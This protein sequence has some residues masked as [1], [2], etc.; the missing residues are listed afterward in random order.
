MNTMLQIFRSILPAR[1]LLTVVLALSLGGCGGWMSQM[2]S[3]KQAVQ[4]KNYP[5]ASV[6]IAK[7]D[8]QKTVTVRLKQTVNDVQ[9]Q[10]IVDTVKTVVPDANNVVVVD[11]GATPN[12]AGGSRPNHK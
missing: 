5:V 7:A 6:G 9:R 8:G 2:S 4:G 3:V 11:G 12:T 1:L 10:E